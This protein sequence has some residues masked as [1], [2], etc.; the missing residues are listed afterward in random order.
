MTRPFASRECCCSPRN[1][2]FAPPAPSGVGIASPFHHQAPPYDTI[3]HS[4][5]PLLPKRTETVCRAPT[6]GEAVSMWSGRSHV[7]D[8]GQD[9]DE[10]SMS[11][12]SPGG[13]SYDPNAPDRTTPPAPDGPSDPRYA[14]DALH[15]SDTTS[16]SQL[17]TDDP[18]TTEPKNADQMNDDVALTNTPVDGSSVDAI[19]HVRRLHEATLETARHS[20]NLLSKQRARRK[21]HDALTEE[22]DALHRLGFDSFGAFAAVHGATPVADDADS[23]ET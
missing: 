17:S 18:T 1:I 14:V 16:E 9:S 7:Q 19:E 22:A 3:P 21:L 12:R 23:A 2:R 10:R 13:D 8:G 15:Q 5:N 11:T 4:V 20:R 6:R